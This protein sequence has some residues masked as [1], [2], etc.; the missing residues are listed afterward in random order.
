[1]AE[2]QAVP[3]RVVRRVVG[4]ACLAPSV[5]NTQPWRWRTTGRGLELHADRRRQLE[6]TDPVGRNL[7]ISCGA[8]LHHARVAADALGWEVTVERHPDPRRPDL[9]A[10][11][12]LRPGSPPPHGADV[13]DLLV[14][15]TTDRRRFTSWPVPEERLEHLAAVAH[16]CGARGIALTEVS[17][18]FRAE[19]LVLLAAQLQRS[20]P[21]ARAEQEEWVD[22]G[23]V[24]GIPH[25]VLPESTHRVGTYAQRFDTSPL[26]PVP[27]PDLESSD[28]LVVLF[29]GHD[30]VPAWLRAGE[31]LSA[32]W[33]AAVREGLSVVPLSQVV[34]VPETRRAFQH[35]VLGGL[36]H[37]LVLVRVGWQA[38]GRD[39]LAR[40]P[41][42]PLDDVLDA[43]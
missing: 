31:G 22:R 4:A 9:L 12:V 39:D 38:I 19:R 23:P 6:V 16:E 32:L 10:R 15:R 30:D 40:T 26:H 8:A 29:D 41:R 7:V 34:E 43:D 3:E 18:R 14:R 37:P 36:A 20:R 17:E 25:Q 21:T 11:L 35:D 24:D 13:L 27:S 2:R 5:H 33:L 28:G 42:R 1:M